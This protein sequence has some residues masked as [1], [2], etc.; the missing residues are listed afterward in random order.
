MLCGYCQRDIIKKLPIH[1]RTAHGKTIR[2]NTILINNL[3]PNN[4]PKCPFC[5][6][7]VMI[8]RIVHKTCDAP[9]CIEKQKAINRHEGQVLE[10]RRR[11]E[12][13]TSNLLKQ[14]L[15][16]DEQGRSIIHLNS[17]RSRMIHGNLQPRISNLER[18][19]AN[20]VRT[21]FPRTTI[22]Y[23]IPETNLPH[24]F[25]IYVPEL[26]LLIEIDG[27]YWHEQKTEWDEE[28]ERIAKQYGYNVERISWDENKYLADGELAQMAD[29][30]LDKYQPQQH[31]FPAAAPESILKEI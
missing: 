29:L 19:I 6:R 18:K 24:P 11:V 15:Q 1:L 23:G 17:Y 7:D 25:D 27:S 12:A 2:D 8:D 30:I 28:C 14:N 13:G 10:N 16:Y 26:N 4:L 9:Y 21:R 5:G 3:D 20:Y 22:Q 31:Y